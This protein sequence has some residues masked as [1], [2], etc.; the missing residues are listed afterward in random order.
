MPREPTRR[1]PPRLAGVYEVA[2]LLEITPSSL[3]DRRRHPS[4]PE[5]VAVLRC[6][7]VWDLDD[8]DDYL[9][10]RRQ[11]PYATYRWANQPYRRRRRRRPYQSWPGWNNRSYG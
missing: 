6:G 4:F 11:D 5:P 9:E 7:P 3:A 2:E 8:V 10:H 1:P